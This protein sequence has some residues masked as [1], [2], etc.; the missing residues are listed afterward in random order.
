MIREGRPEDLGAIT[1]VRTSVVENHLSVEQMAAIGIT[2]EGIIAEMQ[3]G[4][5]GCFVAEEAGRIVGFS[6]ADKRDAGLFALF[7]LPDHEGRGHGKALLAAA[8]DWLR[9]RG[10]A[11]AWLST[12]PETKAFAFYQRHGWRV[13]NETAGHFA[14]DAVM[15]KML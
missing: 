11:E 7:V 6:M 10:I 3:A 2:P 13:T 1:H 4:A 15:R 8:E 9:Q 5:L 14:T 12:G